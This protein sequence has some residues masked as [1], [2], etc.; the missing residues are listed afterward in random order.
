MDR[1]RHSSCA[2]GEVVAGE[3]ALAA[4]VEATLMVQCQGMSWN[5]QARSKFFTHL[6]QNF[7]SRV[8]K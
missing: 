1:D 8:W 5:H 4:F 3:G 6:H 2:C 7:P